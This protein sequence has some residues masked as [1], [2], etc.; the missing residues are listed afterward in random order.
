MIALLVMTDG[1]DDYLKRTLAAFDEHVWGPLTTRIIHDDSG[2]PEHT[3]ML[4]ETYDGY[5]VIGTPERAGFGGAIRS[6]WGLVPYLATD[7]TFIAH[8]EDDFVATRRI[9]LGAIAAVL[10]RHPRLVHMALRRQPWNDE[11][12]AA[13]G[14][15]EIHPEGYRDVTDG[16]DQW[17]EHRMF[18]TTNPSVYRKTLLEVGWPEGV[19]SEGNFAPKLMAQGTAEVGGDDMMFG[20][21]GAR[22]SGTW[23]EHIGQE[24]A[25]TGY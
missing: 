14:I 6:A 22:D 15:V 8:W 3:Q 7:E 20:F 9:D 21:W 25:G 18:W 13:G 16:E 10:D 11:E 2:D 24:R 4:A 1:R 12:K 5:T 17:L 23:V 19:Q